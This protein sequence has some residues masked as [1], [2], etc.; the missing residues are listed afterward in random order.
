MIRRLRSLF[1]NKAATSE[2]VDVNEVVREVLALARSELQ[3]NQVVVQTGLM[4]GLPLVMGDRVQIQ[5]V[6]LNLLLNAMDAMSDVVGRPRTILL[7]SQPAA[8]GGVQVDVRDAGVGFDAT[9]AERLFDAFYTTKDKGMGVGLSVSKSIIESFGGSLWA[10][11]NEGPGATFSFTLP[12][13]SPEARAEAGR[14]LR[15]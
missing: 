15:D 4:P 12:R 6:V 5:Q 10:A 13:I 9:S 11:L 2:L 1:G 7:G 14:S 8:N 3:D